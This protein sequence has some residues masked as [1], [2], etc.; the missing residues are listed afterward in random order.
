MC[1]HQMGR[2][3]FIIVFEDVLH[4]GI[5]PRYVLNRRPWQPK[6]NLVSVKS[7]KDHIGILAQVQLP[8]KSDYRYRIII[9]Y[10]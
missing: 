4:W 6:P 9:F 8:C 1:Q 5:V 10:G 2:G 3:S 7:G